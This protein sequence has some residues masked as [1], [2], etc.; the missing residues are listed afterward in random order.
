MKRHEILRSKI[1][2]TVNDL[3][4][5]PVASLVFISDECQAA[6]VLEKAR[7]YMFD[8]EAGELVHGWL[9]RIP[10]TTCFYLAFHHLAWD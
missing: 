1:V 7:S 6:I 5:I 4:Q 3:Q 2:D 9:L 10:G 8:I